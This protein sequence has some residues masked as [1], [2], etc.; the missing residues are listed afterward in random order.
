[1]NLSEVIKKTVQKTI[2]LVALFGSLA[3]VLSHDSIFR[4]P[5]LRSRTKMTTAQAVSTGMSSR[6]IAAGQLASGRL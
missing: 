1:M 6:E 2:L 4:N 5:T 3:Y